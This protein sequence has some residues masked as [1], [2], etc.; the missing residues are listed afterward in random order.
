MMLVIEVKKDNMCD[1]VCRGFFMVMDLVDYLVKK[2]VLFCDFYE[3]VGKVVVYGVV[4]VKDLFEMLFQ[5]LC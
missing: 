2:G 3:I 4:Q 5:E 1:V